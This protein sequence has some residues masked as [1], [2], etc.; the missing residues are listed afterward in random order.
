LQLELNERNQDIQFLNAER[1]ELVRALG[2]LNKAVPKQRQLEQDLLNSQ[3]LL[4]TPL[5]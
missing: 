4:T 2:L 1:A 5:L 3:V